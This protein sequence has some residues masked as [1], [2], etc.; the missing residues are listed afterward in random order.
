MKINNKKSFFS[1]IDSLVLSFA[2][3]VVCILKSFD[4]K[5][6]LLI[7]SMLLI[8]IAEIR[9]SISSEMARED[10]TA[11]MDERNQLVKWKAQSKSFGIT[12]G[13][14]FTVGLTLVVVGSAAGGEILLFMGTGLLLG[15]NLSMITEIIATVHYENHT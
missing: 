11:D 2:L 1:G 3:L 14:Y 4:L 9:R 8:G 7:I 12:Q 10:K 15:F 13:L 6:I 5:S